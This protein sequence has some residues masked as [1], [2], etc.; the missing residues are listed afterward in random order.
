MFKILARNKKQNSFL[1]IFLI[2]GILVFSA[3][4]LTIVL[5]S[6]KAFIPTCIE[7][8]P[9]ENG[10]VLGYD[11]LPQRKG[12]GSADGRHLQIIKK[13]NT[14]YLSNFSTS[15][16]VDVKTRL[17]NT[18]FL[19]R[20]KLENDDEILINNHKIKVLKNKEDQICFLDIVDNRQITWK[21][22]ELLFPKNEFVYHD[23]SR[24]FWWKMRRYMR[25]FAL[26]HFACKKDKE[27]KLLTLGGGVNRPDRW[28]IEN[29][30]PDSAYVL[31]YNNSFW[32]CPGKNNIP[33]LF[34]K[35]GVKLQS[36]NQLK[37][38]VSGKNGNVERIILGRTHYKVEFLKDI[39]RLFP[40]ENIDLWYD[41]AKLPKSMNSKIK[42]KYEQLSWIAASRISLLDCITE[43]ISK[44]G[45]RRNFKWGQ[46]LANLLIR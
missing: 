33:I 2:T 3:V 39:I 9:D 27:I 25:W 10:I 40:S 13:N 29:V 11:E 14:L 31:F 20:W 42:I 21:N 28:K 18:L 4:I 24:G 32:L 41:E 34:A 30:P 23:K 37:F 43:K 38:P 22:G 19:K 1:D 8:Q 36:F 6:P 35:K 17:H 45:D 7:I 15:K 12:H 5:K 16:K 46:I 44:E 26:K